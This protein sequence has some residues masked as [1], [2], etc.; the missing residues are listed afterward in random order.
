MQLDTKNTIYLGLDG[1]NGE[2]RLLVPRDL[3]QRG[4]KIQE[5]KLDDPDPAS[6]DA[7]EYKLLET[8]MDE[9]RYWT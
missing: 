7:A 8:E 1:T 5:L 4:L 6:T 2:V 3:E 9:T